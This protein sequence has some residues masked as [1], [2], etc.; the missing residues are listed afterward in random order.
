M[1]LRFFQF[2]QRK[3]WGQQ[4]L[5]FSKILRNEKT[6]FSVS[7]SRKTFF[8]SWSEFFNRVKLNWRRFHTTFRSPGN[9]AYRYGRA[10]SSRKT[11]HEASIYSSSDQF[12]MRKVEF[13]I[14][15]ASG[16]PRRHLQEVSLRQP[17][18]VRHFW[19]VFFYLLGVQKKIRS[20][21]A[22]V[23]ARMPTTWPQA[24]HLSWKLYNL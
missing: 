23:K 11:D 12:R 16:L 22:G 13:W 7:V 9:N 18:I 10:A 14:D 6:T 5:I 4:K 19:I 21:I 2:L 24:Q 3:F 17:K 1:S 15:D 8:E 20:R